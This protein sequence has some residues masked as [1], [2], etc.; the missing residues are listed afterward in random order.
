[1]DKIKTSPIKVGELDFNKK[2]E[3]Q[4]NNIV[5]GWVHFNNNSKDSELMYEFLV[6]LQ[7]KV[8]SKIMKETARKI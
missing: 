3:I 1:M 8:I 4:Y 5:V 7:Q 2:L 6:P